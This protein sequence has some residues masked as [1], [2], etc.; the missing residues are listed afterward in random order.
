MRLIMLGVGLAGDLHSH[1]NNKKSDLHELLLTT[2]TNMSTVIDLA[3]ILEQLYS[4]MRLQLG[5]VT[6]GACKE[7]GTKRERSM[8]MTCARTG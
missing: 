2:L 4:R 6:N 7:L 1:L 5:L 3:L 8:R